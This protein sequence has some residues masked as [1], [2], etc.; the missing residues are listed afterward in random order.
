[1]ILRRVIEHVRDQQWTAIAI[2]FVIVVIGVFVGLQVSNW[3]EDRATQRKADVFTAHLRADVIEEHWGYAF[4][5]ACN[6]EVLANAEKAVAALDGTAP[7]D[8][9]ALL[10]VA[11]RATQY[12]QRLRRRST[13]TS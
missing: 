3:N 6:R 8:D 11:Y 4:L 12:K 1:V 13:T 2:D 7:L 10:V 5:I 9:E